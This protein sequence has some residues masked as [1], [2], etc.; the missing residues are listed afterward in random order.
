[1]WIMLVIADVLI[2]LECRLI[3]KLYGYIEQLRG[4][5][6]E[7]RTENERLRKEADGVVFR[8]KTD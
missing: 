1:M 6:K 7:L 5:R 2:L 4:A 3:L 8:I